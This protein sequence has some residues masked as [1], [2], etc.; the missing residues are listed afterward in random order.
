ME[1]SEDLINKTV[2]LLTILKGR[3]D[4]GENLSIPKTA[5]S[6]G[7]PHYPSVSTALNN[8]GYLESS[9]YKSHASKFKLENI[10]PIHARNV[11]EELEKVNNMRVKKARE[12]RKEIQKET[13]KTLKEIEENR[14]FQIMNA[15]LIL[16]EKAVVEL[17]GYR[18]SGDFTIEE[19]NE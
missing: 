15:K 19:I 5:R 18:I 2:D 6:Y 17:A 14:G 7:I 13:N 3:H 10:E 12:K 8:L 16:F 1:I 9:K 4:N 11:L